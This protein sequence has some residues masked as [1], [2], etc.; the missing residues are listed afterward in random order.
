SIQYTVGRMQ[1]KT[2]DDSFAHVT[3]KIYNILGKVLRTLVDEKLSAGTYE[4]L[5]DGKNERQ[6]EVASGV[7]FYKLKAGNLEQT[8][9]MILIR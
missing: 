8:K 1:T 9:K 4:I 2:A 5:W 7:Y 6:E 3:L